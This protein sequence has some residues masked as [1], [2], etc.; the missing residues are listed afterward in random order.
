MPSEGR[1]WETLQALRSSDKGRLCYHRDWLL[2]GEVSGG[3]PE[4][5]VPFWLLATGP[6]CSL[7]PG[8]SC[9][10]NTCI[11]FNNQHLFPDSRVCIFLS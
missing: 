11:L 3:P 9:A 5:A 2:R 10:G 7:A 8:M 4:W 6:C 1:C